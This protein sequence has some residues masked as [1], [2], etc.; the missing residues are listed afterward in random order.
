MFEDL[1]DGFTNTIR[2]ALKI[3]GWGCLITGLLLFEMIVGIRELI[4]EGKA[5]AGASR[6]PE[7]NRHREA[8]TPTPPAEDLTKTI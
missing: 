7:A 2:F 1:V 5:A 6:E 3:V 4:P 8:R